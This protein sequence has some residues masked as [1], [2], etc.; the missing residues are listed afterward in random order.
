MSAAAPAPP[1]AMPEES[2]SHAVSAAAPPTP[3][4]QTVCVANFN[5]AAKAERAAA[6]LVSLGL[7]ADEVRT[8]TNLRERRE[9]L[10]GYDHNRPSIHTQAGVG[11]AIFGGVGA[12]MLSLGVLILFPEPPGME[13]FFIVA[14]TVGLLGACLG[15]AVGWYAF[16]PADD[17]QS[18]LNEKVAQAGPAVAVLDAG[19]LG[20]DGQPIPLGRI[21]RVL[22]REGGT[23][24]YLSPASKADAHP[25]DT[26][27]AD[28]MDAPFDPA[29]DGRPT[30]AA[31][32]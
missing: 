26:R 24:R 22:V 20:S 17:P 10:E 12:V 11:T 13:W 9:F 16:R 21:A 2:K 4:A 31:A 32:H 23:C 18:P 7:P 3:P 30:A 5:D 6:K 28:F 15:G 1:A 14:F 29:P 8:L 19:H 25:G 27:G